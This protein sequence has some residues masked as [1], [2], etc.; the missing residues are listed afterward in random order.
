MADLAH[1]ASRRVTTASPA[2]DRDIYGWAMQ[3]ARLIREGRLGEIDAVNVAEEIESVGRS[4][5]RE[6]G[7]RIELIVRHLLK[8][9]FQP[10][11]RTDSWSNTIAAQRDQAHELLAENPSLRPHLDEIVA[12]AYRLGRREAAR[13]TG[14]PS[15]RFP[16]DCPFSFAQI[17]DEGFVPE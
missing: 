15:S 6:L 16:A 8:W 1:P 3:Q 14:L 17:M 13:E 4:E 11:R 12:R 10:E 9:E 7:S 2:Y 5:R